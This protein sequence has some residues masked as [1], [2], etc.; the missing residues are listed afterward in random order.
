MRERKELGVRDSVVVVMAS[1]FVGVLALVGVP[2]VL[3][4]TLSIADYGLYGQF[5]L[6]LQTFLIFGIAGFPE[7][8]VYFVARRRAATADFL[9]GAM[10]QLAV[11]LLVV[12]AVV[13]LGRQIILGWIVDSAMSQFVLPTLLAV[14]FYAIGD[15]LFTAQTA[16]R[17]FRTFSI[18]YIAF[19]LLQSAVVATVAVVT[20]RLDAVIWAYVWTGGAKAIGALVYIGIEVAKTG[21]TARP[22]MLREQWGYALP[23]TG[24]Q[25]LKKLNGLAHRFFISSSFSPGDFAVYDIATKKVPALG[26]VRGSFVQV[27]TPHFAEME[28]QK[29]HKAILALW[30]ASA[31]RLAIFYFPIT[32]ALIAFAPEAITLVFTD[33]VAAAIPIFRIFALIMVWDSLSGLES[34]LKAF[35]QNRFILWTTA[36]QSAVILSGSWVGLHWLGLAGPAI[37]ALVSFSI[38]QWIRLVRVRALLAVTYGDLLPWRQ[39]GLCALAATASAAV[40]WGLG[41]IAPTSLGTVVIGLSTTFAVYVIGAMRLGLVPRSE[42]ERL[43]AVWRRLVSGGH[44]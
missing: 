41:K 43:A 21:W 14:V 5:Q 8:L 44:D 2:M 42:K 7:A 12:M 39:L 17:R 36:V 10:M 26:L 38:G 22:R 18:V 15:T 9:L 33:K 20:K 6:L 3:I 11:A 19:A 16:Q 37:A 34:L 25:S 40:G 31:S 1:Q 29:R 28:E 35:A 32:A 30:H 23:Y 24:T 13:I 27:M 4:R